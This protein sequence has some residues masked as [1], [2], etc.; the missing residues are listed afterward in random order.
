MDDH[1]SLSTLLSSL[2]FELAVESSADNRISISNKYVILQIRE[3]RPMVAAALTTVLCLYHLPI[4]I[5]TF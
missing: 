1:V 5:L 3:F 2:H 4:P